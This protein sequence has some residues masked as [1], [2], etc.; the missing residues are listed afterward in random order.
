[1]DNKH[2]KVRKI[3]IAITVVLLLL[4]TFANIHA[5]R[6]MARYALELYVY[7][8]LLVA[9]QVGKDTGMKNELSLLLSQDKMPRQLALARS[10]DRKM[11]SLASPGEFLENTTEDLKKKIELY[12]NL[13]NIAFALI[14]A[15]L[16]FRF[17]AIRKMN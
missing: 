5:V 15:I 6:Q 12:R 3:R 13:R 17:F 8:K 2:L 9:Y 11:A 14:I 1:M 10:F 4:F 16:L 7:D